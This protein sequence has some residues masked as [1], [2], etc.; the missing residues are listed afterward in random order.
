MIEKIQT[1]GPEAGTTRP[2]G[3]PLLAYWAIKALV[4]NIITL[5]TSWK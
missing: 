4:Y 2:A 3:K 1:A 5:W